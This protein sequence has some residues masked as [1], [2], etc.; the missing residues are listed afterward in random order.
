[1]SFSAAQRPIAAM[2]SGRTT[3]PEGF[4][5]DV[6]TNIVVL[7]VRARSSS[8]TVTRKPF[9]SEVITGTGLPP[10][11][12]TATGYVVQYG[13]G[14]STSSPGLSLVIMAVMIACLPPLVTSTWL[15]VVR[16]PE[17]RMDL[18]TIASRSSGSPA[19]G[20]YL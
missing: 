9:A 18:A 16:R 2:S 13:A 6:K 3:A 20:V 15:G 10:A 19:V 1:M 5:G 11:R 17:S 12:Y 8:S 14:I 4:D 7:G